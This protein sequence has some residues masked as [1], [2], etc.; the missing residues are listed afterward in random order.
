A[1]DDA[2]DIRASTETLYRLAD[3]CR[4]SRN[5]FRFLLGNLGDFEPARDRQSYARLDEIDRWILD[6]LARLIGRVRRAY[7]E[8]EFHTIFHSVHNFCAVD[9]SALYLDV[10]KDRLYTSR[11]D[12]PRRRAAQTV[13]YEVFGTLARLVAPILTFTCEE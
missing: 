4:R 5:T 1:E 11:P 2:H 7:E 8:Y 10:I 3:G 13:C 6:R 9:L 12:D